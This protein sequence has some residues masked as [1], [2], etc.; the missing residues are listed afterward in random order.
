[1]VDHK[2]K[3]YSCMNL[4]FIFGC[5]KILIFFRVIGPTNKINPTQPDKIAR[6]NTVVPGPVQATGYRVYKHG[7]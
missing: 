6:H 1:M 3:V 7:V 5:Y 2:S 4:T